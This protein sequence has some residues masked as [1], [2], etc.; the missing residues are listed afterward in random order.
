M[1]ILSINISAFWGDKIYIRVV[2]I[3]APGINELSCQTKKQPI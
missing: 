3:M 2:N 1:S